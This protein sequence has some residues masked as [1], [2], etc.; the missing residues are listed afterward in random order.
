MGGTNGRTLLMGGIVVS[1]LG[2]L[3]GLVSYNK[4]RN[5]PVH[6]SMLE[7]SELIYE[8]YRRICSRRANS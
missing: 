1:L 8:T 6:K 3:F 5:L 2:L 7:I 4:L